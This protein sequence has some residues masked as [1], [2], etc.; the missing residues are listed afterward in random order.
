L[1]EPGAGGDY[2]AFSSLLKT[3]GYEARISI[4]AYSKDLR[5]DAAASLKLL[6]EVF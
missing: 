4:E 2:E 6:R 5:S 1:P 3:I